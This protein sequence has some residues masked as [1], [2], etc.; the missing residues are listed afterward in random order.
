MKPAEIAHHC[1]VHPLWLV[2]PTKWWERLHDWSGRLAFPEPA[3]SPPHGE[4]PEPEE[5]DCPPDCAL[6]P[7]HDG[8]VHITAEYLAKYGPPEPTY[9]PK[10]GDDVEVT[11]IARM[12]SFVAGGRDVRVAVRHCTDE[13][14]QDERIIHVPRSSVRPTSDDPKTTAH[15]CGVVGCT[16][17]VVWTKQTGSFLHCRCVKHLREDYPNEAHAMGLGEVK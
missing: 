15:S 8:P 13:D 17:P 9:V 5:S 6:P 14:C 10:V 4:R 1:L 12:C 16:D 7:G 3:A 2:L 11:L